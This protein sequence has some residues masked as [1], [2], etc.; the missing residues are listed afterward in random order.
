MGFDKTFTQIS[1]DGKSNDYGIIYGSE[2]VFFVKCGR[3]GSFRGR[4]DKYA[5]MAIRLHR[6][7]G[8]TVIC[9]SNPL[10]CETSYDLDKAVIEAYVAEKGTPDFELYLIGNSNGAYQNLFLANRLAQVKKI[11]CIN[12]PLMQNFHKS[13][14]EVQ[15]LGTVEKIFV[16]GTK[17]PSYT[18][19]PFLERRNYPLLRV[20]RLQD[21]GHQFRDTEAFISLSDLI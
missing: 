12:M 18:Y 7:R 10:D 11:L 14:K 4:D 19:V 6:A 15:A 21:V 9:A 16:Y 17:D 1:S 5:K 8:C 20:I 13:T 2:T 3:G